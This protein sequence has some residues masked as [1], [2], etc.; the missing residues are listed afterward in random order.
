MY[1]Y[2]YIYHIYIIYI[3]MCIY[4]HTCVLEMFAWNV[5]SLHL[6][7]WKVVALESLLPFVIASSRQAASIYQIDWPLALRT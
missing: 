1:V 7:C 2:I 4:I 6:F 5:F 3:Y